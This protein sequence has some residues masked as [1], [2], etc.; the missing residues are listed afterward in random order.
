MATG[1]SRPIKELS[2]PSAR[3]GHRLV[4]TTLC[5]LATSCAMIDTVVVVDHPP[6]PGDAARVGDPLPGLS[7][8]QLA[9]FALA[10]TEFLEHDTVDGHDDTTMGL[11]PRFNLDGCADCHAFPAL[12]GSSPPI[13]REVV[14]AHAEGATNAASI[15]FLK[16]DGPT[17][18][19]RFKWQLDASGR[20]VSG[21]TQTGGKSGRVADGGV[22]ALFTIAGR[23][24]ADPGCRIEQPPFQKAWDLDNVT[25]RIPTPVFGL[26]LIEAI[27]E[28]TINHNAARTVMAMANA[29]KAGTLKAA[30][31]GAEADD[32]GNVQSRAAMYTTLGIHGRPGRGREN[33]CGNDGTITRFGWKAQNKSLLLFSGEA[34]NVEQG[35]TNDLFPNERDQEPVAL[36]PACKTNATPED[37]IRTAFAD[38]PVTGSAERQ[39]NVAPGDI[40]LFTAFMRLLAPPK[41]SCDLAR[42][43]A[44]NV[45]RGSA[46]FDQIYC[47]ACHVRQLE[48]GKSPVDA[49]S[50]QKYAVLY[51]DLLLHK[52]GSCAP[53]ADHSNACLADGVQ[54]GQAQGDEFRTAPLWGLG[55][56]LFLL[57]DGR[58][59]NLNEAILAHRGTG[60]EANAVIK[61][62]LALPGASR[63]DL[64]DFLRTL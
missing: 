43:C 39:L 57:H 18:E 4:V 40:D 48:I 11:G 50:Q 15:P 55:Q 23:T 37:T 14:I 7:A 26:G 16:A 34:Y 44:A 22:H 32:M 29:Q 58:T 27:D 3:L 20:F 8:E 28:V 10:R 63:Q 38:G 31:Y 59:S 13:N 53:R 12:G 24:D 61:R 64:V 52:M 56:R 54:Q 46:V 25:L 9:L 47:S 45:V 30:D 17:V 49:I 21:N 19:V 60:S 2:L 62:Y 1:T 33:L 6:Q 5:V 41:P 42:D 36:S 51:S 35:V